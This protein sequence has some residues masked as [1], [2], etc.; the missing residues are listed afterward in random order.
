[1]SLLLTHG[2]SPACEALPGARVACF[3]GTTVPILTPGELLQ[4]ESG[5]RVYYNLAP[6]GLAPKDATT[7]TQFRRQ[8]SY[9]V[10][11]KQESQPKKGGGR[12]QTDT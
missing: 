12:T 9:F 3:T 11:V 7:G 2:P 6:P 8:C 1:M 5:Y 10:P 4:Y